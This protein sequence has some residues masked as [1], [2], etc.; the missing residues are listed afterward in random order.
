MAKYDDDPRSSFMKITHRY[1]RTFSGSFIPQELAPDATKWDPPADVYETETAFIV[2]VEAGGMHKNDFEIKL[3]ED[4]L[5]I[6][7]CRMETETCEKMRM[8]QMELN[9]GPFEKVI[10]NIPP[11]QIDRIQ[12]TYADGF[13][14]ITLPKLDADKKKMD[15][16]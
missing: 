8:H 1:C 3:V 15:I 2:R 7:G 13:L 16:R 4:S 6:R 12:A 11:V 9:Y 10:H 14:V 5:H